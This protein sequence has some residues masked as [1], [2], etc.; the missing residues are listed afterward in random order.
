MQFEKTWDLQSDWLIIMWLKI[1][2]QNFCHVIKLD[3]QNRIWK[4]GSQGIVHY[5]PKKVISKNRL[6][7]LKLRFFNFITR[8]S[9]TSSLPLSTVVP[10]QR[11]PAGR[12]KY[13]FE[14]IFSSTC[15]IFFRTCT[16]MVRYDVSLVTK[17][18]VTLRT[19]KT[20]IIKK[21]N[22]WE[23]TYYWHLNNSS[24]YVI[25]FTQSA[26]SIMLRDKDLDWTQRE[27]FRRGRFFSRG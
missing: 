10:L 19:T 22:F 13:L 1:L 16:K 26:I 5:I 24:Y 17:W 3:S 15:T 11:Y 4:S 18:N 7:P 6:Q 9:V 23:I 8:W 14:D 2:E 25:S 20:V 21:M 27:T 12:P